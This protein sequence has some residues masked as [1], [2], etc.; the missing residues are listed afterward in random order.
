MP[1]GS[2]PDNLVWDNSYSLPPPR[3][4]ATVRRR[5]QHLSLVPVPSLFLCLCPSL[6]LL[7]SPFPPL[8]WLLLSLDPFLQS[9]RTGRGLSLLLAKHTSAAFIIAGY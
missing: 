6:P 1:R 9:A 3:R 5:S 2:G 7:P 4:Y 8:P